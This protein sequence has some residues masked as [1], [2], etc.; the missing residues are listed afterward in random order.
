MKFCQG[1]KSEDR[2]YDLLMDM[3]PKGWEEAKLI[4][5]KHTASMTLKAD[6][7]EHRPRGQVHVVNNMSVAPTSSSQSPEKKRKKYHDDNRGRDSTPQD[8][9]RGS[10]QGKRN[11]INNSNTRLCFNCDKIST[12]YAA[13]F[14]KPKKEEGEN[15]GRSITPYPKRGDSSKESGGASQGGDTY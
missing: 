2:L 7:V 4:I 10:S 11:S 12:H 8:K 14:P 1:L 5:R 9:G 15:E 3:D 6:L 13:N